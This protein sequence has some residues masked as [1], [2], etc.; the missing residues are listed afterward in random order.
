MYPTRI[1]L[2]ENCSSIIDQK[3]QI[4]DQKHKEKAKSFA[5][6][7]PLAKQQ[8]RYFNEII[9]TRLPLSVQVPI[10]GNLWPI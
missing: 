6:Y 2:C 3:D 1:F 5:D 10:V 4:L 7:F 9:V 8:T